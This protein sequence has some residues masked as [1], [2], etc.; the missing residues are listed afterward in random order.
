MLGPSSEAGLADAMVEASGIADERQLRIVCQV[1]DA[2]GD[3]LNSRI[4][5]VVDFHQGSAS[6][7]RSLSA[8]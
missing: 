5:W 6:C 3:D 8:T 4:E 1:S 2:R 7:A